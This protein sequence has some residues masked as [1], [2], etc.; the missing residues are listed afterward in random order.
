MKMDQ[1]IRGAGSRAPS[2][3]GA[4]PY[5]TAAWKALRQVI[6]GRDGGLCQE[7]GAQIRGRDWGIRHRHPHDG[8]PALFWAPANLELE[9]ANC[10][11][12]RLRRRPSHWI[13]LSG[14]AQ[15]A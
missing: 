8:D 9:C 1:T 12:V 15:R 14:D 6:F 11:R 13:E 4:V 3:P 5:R 2:K 7:C 10:S